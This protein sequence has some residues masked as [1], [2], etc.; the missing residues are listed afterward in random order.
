MLFPQEKIDE[1]RDAVDIVDI[2]SGYIDLRKKGKNFFA[3]CPF[4]SEKTSSFSVNQENQIFHCFGCG[5][6]GNV[7]TFVKM[8]E[9]ISFP[10]AV[11][12]LASRA[13][14][15]LKKS[16]KSS[17]G[18]KRE[19][20]YTM[21]KKVAEWYHS[22]LLNDT[23]GEKA[24]DYLTDRGITEK[25]IKQF[26]LGYAPSQWDGVL[27]KYGDTAQR[28]IV[29]E[30][31]GLIVP[32]DRKEGYYDRFRNRIMFP[33]FDEQGRVVGF[34]GR[35]L[36]GDENGAKY[37][38]TPETEIY[39]KSKLLYG[40]H[41]HKKEIQK[42]NMA[43]IVEG[44]M[45]LI[46]P[47]QAGFRKIVAPLGTA[48]TPSQA[49]ILARYTKNIT[50]IFDSDEAGLSATMRGVDILI[51]SGLDVEIVML[52][53]GHDP[54]STLKEIGTDAFQKVLDNR[55]KLFE[56]WASYYRGGKL[57]T[58][59]A[60]TK[61]VRAILGVIA[62]IKDNIRKDS[63]LV[64]VADKFELNAGDLRRELNKVSKNSQRGK[65]APG[66]QPDKI[67]SEEL[68]LLHLVFS[69]VVIA[70][71]VLK[72]VSSGDVNDI[73]VKH[74][75]KVITN[76][77]NEGLSISPSTLIDAGEN[78]T[79][80]KLIS[81]IISEKYPITS[82]MKDTIDLDVL[83]IQAVDVINTLR[84]RKLKRDLSSMQLRLKNEESK[85]GDTVPLIK[86]YMECKEK[87]KKLSKE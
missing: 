56:F 65:T 10:E 22:L 23:A 6:G 28:K 75:I 43:L 1:I 40:L 29:L 54:D 20:L 84:M 80:N 48:L 3:L 19:F 57:K 5:S 41:Q 68:E 21:N 8:I 81:R 18:I 51:E 73:L 60:K 2:I 44:Y 69:D 9:K 34:G 17:G 83:K 76:R 45:D 61:M 42:S 38:N 55:V 85:G 14:I 24:L 59:D 71:Y 26:N 15:K 62:K 39:K 49:G 37:M 50:L 74:A 16:E 64:E 32:R 4:H 77:F 53:K 11:E 31:V 82:A 58:I 13:G 86:Q 27:K 63:M 25:T 78:E 67:P 36:P 70:E 66:Y 33:I 79:F 7:F 30:R 46:T 87:I 47:A 52:E 72:N 12:M 35:A